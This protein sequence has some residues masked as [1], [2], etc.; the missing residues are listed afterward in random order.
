MFAAATSP[1]TL[2]IPGNQPDFS[3]S[4]PS[5]AF[6]PIQPARYHFQLSWSANA[7]IWISIACL[8]QTAFFSFAGQRQGAFTGLNP[9][10]RPGRLPAKRLTRYYS[11]GFPH[12][13]L[14][15]PPHQPAASSS[16]LTVAA[17]SIAGHLN[18]HGTPGIAYA[19][20]EVRTTRQRG[21]LP[22]QHA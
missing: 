6:E 22:P 9:P 12:L 7:R 15:G 20:N 19:F 2:A 5:R 4:C 16:H 13:S 11:T 21:L 18:D 1:L 8:Q 3:R 14:P 17:L 10:R